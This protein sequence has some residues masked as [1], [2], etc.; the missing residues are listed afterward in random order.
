MSNIYIG[1][2]ILAFLGIWFALWI[3]DRKAKKEDR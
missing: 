1:I 3:R 2:A